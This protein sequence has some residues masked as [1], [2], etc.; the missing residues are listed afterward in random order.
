MPFASRILV[1]ED[2]G[3]LASNLRTFLARHAADVRVAADGEQALAM[4]RSFQ[5]DV[6]VIDYGLPDM[7]GL[8]TYSEMVRSLNEPLGCVMITGYPVEDLARVAKAHGVR[9]VLSKP[10]QLA[11]LGEAVEKSSQ[12]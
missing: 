5:P 10:F 9:H 12:Q 4:L 3:P 11:E 6:A 7:N 2:E 1:V 8:Q